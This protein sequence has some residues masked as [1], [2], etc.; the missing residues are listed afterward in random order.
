MN[1]VGECCTSVESV[2]AVGPLANAALQTS[3]HEY[4]AHS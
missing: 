4:D 1:Q 2:T 3:R